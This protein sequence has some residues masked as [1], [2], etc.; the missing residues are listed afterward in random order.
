MK[1][2]IRM[3]KRTVLFSFELLF[4]IIILSIQSCNDDCPDSCNESPCTPSD[5]FV[6]GCPDTSDNITWN[7]FGNWKFNLC[8]DDI[9]AKQLISNCD[10]K[11]YKGHEGG[12]GEVLEISADTNNSVVFCWAD[13][14]FRS[15]LVT[16]GWK[17]KTEKGVKIGSKL[18]NFLSVY[19]D[20]EE[21]SNNVWKNNSV[22]HPVLAKFSNDSILIEILVGCYFEY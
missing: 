2:G 7:S 10:W 6:L 21:L 15:F 13:N 20:F 16:D 3:L 9:F 22:E 11:I 12:E 1:K 5:F 19:P 18:D 4:V 17:G 14:V 8:G